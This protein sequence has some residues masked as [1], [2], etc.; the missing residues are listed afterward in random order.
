MPA[1][2]SKLAIAVSALGLSFALNV[3]A[4]EAPRT[5]TNSVGV[6][7]EA[8]LMQ[9]EGSHVSLLLGNGRMVSIQMDKL[10]PQDQAYVRKWEIGGAA[11][12][13]STEVASPAS[14]PQTS[15]PTPALVS[16]TAGAQSA[17]NRPRPGE[18][19]PIL[20]GLPGQPTL[21]AQPSRDVLVRALA[22]H[23]L[24]PDPKVQP[25]A[26][27]YLTF[28]ELGMS[29]TGD[30]PLGMHIRI[31]E[32][33]RP[34]RPVPIIV[35]MAG[36]DGS[37]RF[38]ETE[39]MVNK[40]DFVLVGINY[41]ASAPEP[42]YATRDGQID[43]VWGVQEK[44]LAKLVEIIPNTDPRLRIA[45][46]FSNGAHTIGGCLGQRVASFYAFF[47]VYVLVE[48]GA[49]KTYNYPPLPGRYF[50]VTWGLAEGG[51]GSD[52]GM[53]LA[54]QAARAGMKVE[55]HGMEGVSHGF[56]ATE[57]ARVKAWIYGEVIPNLAP[58]I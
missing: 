38:N 42:R 31:P 4:A 18:S 9:V 6:K 48:G 58:G 22:R 34:D 40:E 27:L 16:S 17:G 2:L 10:S 26:E 44:M 1:H 45:V 7:M 41:P 35:W 19:L 36:G 11:Q 51:Y 52:F 37:S 28:P 12:D 25:K 53:N 23:D 39:S 47:N 56:P 8:T 20:P 32:T 49:S 50:Y 55:A 46:G 54:R 13:T 33:Y 30:E 15:V 3:T 24:T 14:V 21:R 43:Q 57:E 5:W 29:R